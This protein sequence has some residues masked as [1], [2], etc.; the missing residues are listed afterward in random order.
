VVLGSK[1]ARYVAPPQAIGI[2]YWNK[3]MLDGPMISLEDGALLRPKVA[4][5]RA[6]AIPL[7]SGGTIPAEHYNISGEFNVDVWYD[8]TD[9]WA[10]LALDISDGSEVRYERL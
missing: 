1:T 3:R 7:A 8:R 9:T 10:S 5:R 4:E 2:S 6:D